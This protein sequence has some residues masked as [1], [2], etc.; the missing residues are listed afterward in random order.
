[1]NT[2]HNTHYFTNIT[3]LE[4]LK[5]QYR[6]LALQYHPDRPQGNSDIF[7]AIVSEY[8]QLHKLVKDTHKTKDGKT[9]TKPVNEK[10]SDF[11]DLINK[12]INLYGI[13]IEVIGSF[14]WVSGETKPHKDTLK[15]LG[16]RWHTAKKAWY[17][18]PTDY[19]KYNRNKKYSMNEIRD[20]YGVQ[21]EADSKSNP[22]LES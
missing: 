9:Y 22:Q 17:K 7:K 2:T 8:E 19:I 18:A 1:M 12:L 11:I 14:V 13:H 21:F 15:E 20:M 3:T 6:K 4:E 16:F 10:P 5:K